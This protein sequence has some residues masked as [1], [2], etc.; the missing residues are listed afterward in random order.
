MVKDNGEE[1]GITYREVNKYGNCVIPVVRVRTLGF[2][3]SRTQLCH[4]GVILVIMY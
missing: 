3:G 4:C 1:T 2:V